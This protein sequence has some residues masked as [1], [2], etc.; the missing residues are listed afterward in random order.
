MAIAQQDLI[1]SPSNE[2][3]FDVQPSHNPSV[4]QPQKDEHQEPYS[5]G[6]VE[7]TPVNIE[8]LNDLENSLALI[9]YSIQDA[10]EFVK[11]YNDNCMELFKAIKGLRFNDLEAIWS[12]FWQNSLKDNDR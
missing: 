10:S 12:S 6:K 7:F 2:Q 8:N 9:G 1:R 3:D 11:Q 4:S 5:F